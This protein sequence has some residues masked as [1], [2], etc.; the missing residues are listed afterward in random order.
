MEQDLERTLE[1]VKADLI[2]PAI[3]LVRDRLEADEYRPDERIASNYGSVTVKMLQP[4][5]LV[6][7]TN[8]RVVPSLVVTFGA[9]YRITKHRDGELLLMRRTEET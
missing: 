3:A 1:A 2:E 7:Y 5:V 8:H 9:A 6:S 4:G